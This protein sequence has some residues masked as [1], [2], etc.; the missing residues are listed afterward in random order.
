MSLASVK[1]RLVLPFWY[2]LTRVVPEKGLLNG[3]VCVCLYPKASLLN[4]VNEKNQ[5]GANETGF[6]CTMAVEMWVV[7][8]LSRVVN[9]YVLMHNPSEIF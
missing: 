8:F 1:S 3:C 5:G 4:H 7:I 6:I 2:R 9:S